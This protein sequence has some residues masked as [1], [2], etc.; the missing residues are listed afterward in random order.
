M[1]AGDGAGPAARGFA[2]GWGLPLLAEPTSG[3]RGGPNLVAA[4]RLLLDEPALGGRIEHVVVFGRPTLSRPVTRLLARPEVGW[5][6]VR[7]TRTT[8]ARSEPDVTVGRCRGAGWLAGLPGLRRVDRRPGP[9]R[10]AGRVAAGRSGRARRR[11]TRSWTAGR[12]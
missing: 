9:R 1:V 3:S 8:R 5:I 11:W 7:A 12:S 6:L 4:Y 2:E 10:L